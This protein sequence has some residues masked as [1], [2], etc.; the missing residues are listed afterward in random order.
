M[1]E[2]DYLENGPI[3]YKKPR[4][5]R[6]RKVMQCDEKG[7]LI[8]C[9]DSIQDASEMTRSSRTSI[10]GC[11]SGRYKKANGF[12][13]VYE[14]DFPISSLEEHKYNKKGRKIAQIDPETN[15]IIKTFERIK[16]AGDELG[17]NYKTI[18]KV[19]DLPN[20]TAYGFK[21]ISQ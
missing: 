6:C 9:F 16:E 4:S 14:T 17:V 5:A 7:N 3:K 11:L 2:E 10:L 12:I 1:Y 8:A 15:H 20:R 18:H 19:L 13:W 21:W